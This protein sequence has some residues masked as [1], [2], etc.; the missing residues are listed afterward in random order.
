MSCSLN[1]SESCDTNGIELKCVGQCRR[2]RD[3]ILLGQCAPPC[4]E[5][6]V[7]GLWGAKTRCSAPRSQRFAGRTLILAP[8]TSLER[9]AKASYF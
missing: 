9:L 4:N 1:K 7:L 2:L 6:L 3:R 8:H 5:R